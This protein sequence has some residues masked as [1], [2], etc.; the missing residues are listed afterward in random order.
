MPHSIPL[1]TTLATA[2]GLALIFGYIAQLLK[3]PIIVGYLFAGV[4]IGPHTPGFIADAAI[5][6]ELAEIGVM[7]LMFGVGLHFSINDLISVR[8]IAVPGALIQILVATLLGAAMATFW[9]WTFGSA[10]IF[11]ISLSIAS[12]V[13]LLRAL[14]A[15]NLLDT[16]SGKI[17]VGWLVVEDLVMVIVIV[18]LPPFASWINGGIHSGT[19]NNLLE[20]LGIT[21]LEVSGFIALIMIVGRKVFP[22]ILMAINRTGTR[23]LFTLCVIAT[24]ISIAFIATKLF[25]V[26]LALG[27]FFAGMMLNESPLSHRAAEESLPLREAFAVLFFV[28]VGML[29]DPTVIISHPLQIL[30]VI[31]IIVFGKTFAAAALVLFL[32]YPL[33]TA[34]L[35][36]AS[37]AQIGEFSFILAGLGFKL[38]ILP[39]EGQSLILAGALISIA[40]NPLLFKAATP[41]E[42]FLTKRFSFLK[43]PQ[44][45]S[46][47]PLTKLPSDINKTQLE[48]LI[49]LVGYGIVGQRISDTLKK[50]NAHFV[51]IE[52]NRELVENLREQNLVAIFGDATEASTLHRAKAEKANMLVIAIPDNFNAR[53]I[54]SASKKVNPKIG[55]IT[56]VHSAEEEELLKDQV[57]KVFFVEAEIANNISEYILNQKVI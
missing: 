15:Y 53:K 8:K 10:I 12:T 6:S 30:G 14:E 44:Q 36:S 22:K 2:F 25:G 23:E 57:S 16:M 17:A 41:L 52:Q 28:S 51:I 27:A 4:I 56:R 37:L 20:K 39:A 7:L 40:L 49:I 1:I 13:V 34:L 54:I 5:A 11:G 21:L 47:D 55:I 18:L 45:Q 9:G 24:A 3:L 29:F 33:N 46:I 42:V 26:S 43:K 19:E 32:R 31:C 48:G 50:N 35:V 38:G